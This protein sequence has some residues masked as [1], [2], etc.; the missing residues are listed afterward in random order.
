[1]VR[2][3]YGSFWIFLVWL[4]GLTLLLRGATLHLLG[5]FGMK[6]EAAAEIWESRKL[7]FGQGF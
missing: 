3:Q 5:F 7:S 2:T 4:F 1:M 6:E